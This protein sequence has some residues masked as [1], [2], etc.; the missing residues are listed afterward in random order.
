MA[1]SRIASGSDTQAAARA[2]HLSALF[3]GR[4]E[5]ATSE[6]ARVPIAKD[7]LLAA[8]RAAAVIDPVETDRVLAEATRTLAR[9]G[10]YLLDVSKRRGSAR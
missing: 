10:D 2:K 9:L 5:L 6:T 8:A 1:G 3:L 7:H 4:Y